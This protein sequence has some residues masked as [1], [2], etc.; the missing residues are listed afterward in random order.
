MHTYTEKDDGGENGGENLS[1]SIRDK[2][3]AGTQ[4]V[5]GWR[6]P[7]PQPD[8]LGQS[9]LHSCHRAPI[10]R[11]CHCLLSA[12]RPPHTTHCLPLPLP[13]PPFRSIPSPRN[14]KGAVALP[15]HAAL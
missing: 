6:K 11:A 9:Q 4:K 7:C 15:A 12:V 10:E 5:G 14:P 1:V 13:P 3:C 8:L 2:W